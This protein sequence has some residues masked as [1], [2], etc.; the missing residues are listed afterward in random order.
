MKKLVVILA[1]LLFVTGVGA[2]L[3]ASQ[4]KAGGGVNVPSIRLIG[5]QT[6]I[7][8]QSPFQVNSGAVDKFVPENGVIYQGEKIFIVPLKITNMGRMPY[9]V[10]ISP[11]INEGTWPNLD[12]RFTGKILVPNKIPIIGPGETLEIT[13]DVSVSY[14]SQNASFKGLFLDIFPG[15]AEIPALPEK[16]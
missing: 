3:I 1:A 8:V 10:N 4:V 13:V 15:P 12:L 9:S 16:G 7:S 5:E 6:S 14:G 2:A 11:R